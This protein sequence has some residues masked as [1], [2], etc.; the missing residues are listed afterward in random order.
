MKK[1]ISSL[2]FAMSIFGGVAHADTDYSKVSATFTYDEAALETEAGAAAVLQNL[3]DQA[4]RAC[5]KVSL[6][7]LGLAVDEVCAQD[8]MF[9]AVDRIGPRNLATQYAASDY[10]TAQPSERIQL[11]AR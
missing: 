6:V 5:R 3:E 9:Q 4:E 7:T 8:L 10:F 2:L 1:R 11:A